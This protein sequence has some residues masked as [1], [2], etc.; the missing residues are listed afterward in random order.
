[1]DVDELIAREEIRALI[2]R[3]NHAGDRGRLDELLDCFDADGVMEIDGVAPLQGHPAIRRHLAGVV[4]DLAAVSERATLRHHVSSLSIELDSPLAA[5]AWS[6]FAVFTEAGLD[7]WGRYADRL[8]RVDA[9]WRFAHRRVRVD[10]ASP[11]SRMLR[12]GA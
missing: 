9:S 5:R 11:G 10:G 12:S 8:A 2:A 1:M 6:Y 3:Y 7:H 4:A